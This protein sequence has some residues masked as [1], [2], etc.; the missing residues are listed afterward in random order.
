MNM[1]E[2]I[3]NG[4]RIYVGKVVEIEGELVRC[5]LIDTMGLRAEF[6]ILAGNNR[7]HWRLHADSVSQG[8]L[9]YSTS[10]LSI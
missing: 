10:L 4:Q 1:N 9:A 8:C 6:E 5:M 2:F 7:A 3:K